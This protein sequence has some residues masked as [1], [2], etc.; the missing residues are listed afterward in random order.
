MDNALTNNA[1]NIPWELIAASLQG[2]LDAEGTAK[3]EQWLSLSTANREKYS[4]WQRLWPGGLTNYELYLSADAPAGWTSLQE[5]ISGEGSSE[6][7]LIRGSFGKK[8]RTRL[9]AAAVIVLLAG[10]G[11]LYFTRPA[12]ADLYYAAE[13]EQKNILLPDGSSVALQPLTSIQV[14]GDYNKT[15]RTITLVKG[16][17]LFEVQHQAQ[18][19][20]VVNIGTTSVKDIGTSFTI[21]K[22]EDSIQVTV[23]TGKVA[24]VKNS[25]G[26]QRELSGGMALS[27]HTHAERFGEI[28]PVEQAFGA[29][30][31]D[32]TYQ[33]IPLVDFIA[34]VEKKYHKKIRLEDS[35]MAQM[36]LT[37][38]L[39]GES[40]GNVMKTICASLNLQ[41]S[42]KDGCYILKK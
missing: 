23:H 12:P 35:S 25:T 22:R 11:W 33:D 15:G 8:I 41:Y 26:E 19:P 36:K 32:S 42:E 34:A 6:A 9:A 38:R 28:I 27:F 20:F 5:R 24:F 7:K 17:A 10:A 16:E 21:R 37:I 18:S 1:E 31:P 40:F 30:G 3:L 4:Q 29:G 14:A 39:G 2:D 13:N